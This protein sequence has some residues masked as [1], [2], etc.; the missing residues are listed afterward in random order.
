MA[1]ELK[2]MNPA[3]NIEVLGINEIGADR[4][5]SQ[6]TSFRDL[7]WLQDTPASSTWSLWQAV[8]RDVRILDPGN[9]L[10]TVFNV[11][12]R[13]L[14]RATNY[15]ALRQ[16]FL[17]AAA[18]VDTDGD[19]LLDE[20]EWQHFGGLSAARDGD[21]DGDGEDNASEYAFCTDPR[22]AGS[23]PSFRVSVTGAWDGQVF[24]TT[25]RRRAGAA[26]RYVVEGSTDLAHWSGAPSEFQFTE[27][28]RGLFD[29][30]G[31]VES[32]WVLTPASWQPLGFLR[33]RAEVR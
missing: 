5:N 19:G 18:F 22:N 21:A 10:V 30:S 29:G 9:R 4:Y 6:V 27:T 3:I 24:Q 26:V 16:A 13:D 8:W 17:D 15:V 11:T 12:D 1:G 20:W 31:A 14:R 23:R 33:V 28:V 7:P 25:F 2:A 32:T